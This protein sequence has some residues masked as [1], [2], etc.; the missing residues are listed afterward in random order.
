MAPA[1][2][3]EASDAEGEDAQR[4]AGRV[5][6]GVGGDTSGGAGST[7]HGASGCQRRERPGE[8]EDRGRLHRGVLL[9]VG[10]SLLDETS[11][12]LQGKAVIHVV[13]YS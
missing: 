9:G 12:V 10:V 5:T 13:C 2:G 4:V 8:E 7:R 6:G 3:E 1:S 11:R